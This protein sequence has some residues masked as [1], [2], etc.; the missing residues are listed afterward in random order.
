MA[1]LR[2]LSVRTKPLL[3]SMASSVAALTLASVAL[4]AYDLITARDYMRQEH[5]VLAKVIGDRSTA[6]L[7]FGDDESATENLAASGARQSIVSACI[8]TEE[9]RPFATYE[10]HAGGGE[11]CPAGPPEDGSRFGDHAFLIVQP[12][13]LDEARIGTVYLRSHLGDLENRSWRYAGIMVLVILL[14]AAVAFF[15]SSGLQWFVSGPIRRLAVAAAAISREGD[16]SIRALKT[17]DDEL[18]VLVD[19]FNGMLTTIEQQNLDVVAANSQLAGLVDE[20]EAKNAELERFTYT[21]SHDLKSPLITIKGFLGLLQKDA[22]A[23]DLDRMRKDS[24]RI[25]AAADKMGRLLGELLELSRIGR[26]TNPP[27]LASMSELVAEG[28]E[29][30]SGVIRERGVEVAVAG[31]MPP[32]HVDRPRLIE[33]IQNL[34]ENAVKFMGKE[35]TPR[36]EIGVDRERVTGDEVAYFVRDNGIGIDPKYHDKVFGLFERLETGT[37]GTGIGLAIAKKIIEVHGGRIWVESA[38]EGEG[39]IFFFTLPPGN[40]SAPPGGESM[41]AQTLETS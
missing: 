12:I 38:G 1:A 33:V 41:A 18:G 29:L 25:H 22:E 32:V 31:D 20:L 15:L 30:A 37:E 28:V 21:V 14:G 24:R 39:S 17:S 10:R 6:A 11:P 13:E 23:G 19:A 7:I 4:M 3:I 27:E 2:R 9:G 16:Y 40:E 8:Y 5:E 35:E 34:I 26:I 36:I